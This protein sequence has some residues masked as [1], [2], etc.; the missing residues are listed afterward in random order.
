[1]TDGDISEISTYLSVLQETLYVNKKLSTRKVAR[2]LVNIKRIRQQ[3]QSRDLHTW[4]GD[5]VPN[6]H[7]CSSCTGCLD[8]C[9]GTLERCKAR[10][11]AKSIDLFSV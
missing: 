8:N 11:D 7:V 4:I 2:E 9:P 6:N 5:I 10:V 3:F 1:M